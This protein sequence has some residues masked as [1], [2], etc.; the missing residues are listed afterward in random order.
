MAL[1]SF[2]A[3][4]LG[5]R[6][7]WRPLSTSWRRWSEESSSE[8]SEEESN[9]AYFWTQENN[10]LQHQSKHAGRIYKVS[11]FHASLL[12]EPH[13]MMMKVPS[14]IREAESTMGVASEK[15]NR[16]E[17]PTLKFRFTMFPSLY[18]EKCDCLQEEVILIRKP[19]VEIFDVLRNVDT[20]T[21]DKPL[22]L[23]LW[24]KNG[25]E[26]HSIIA[27]HYRTYTGQGKSLT[28]AHV[29]HYFMKSQD[30]V[31]VDFGHM[32]HWFHHNNKIEKSATKEGLFNH[33]QDSTMQ[34]KAFKEYNADKVANLTTKE[35][36]VWSA[37]E[38]TEK[39]SPLMALVEHGLD[40]PKFVADAFLCLLQELKA[41]SREGG[42]KLAVTFD[43]VN[44][45]FNETSM[46][47]RELENFRSRQY[48][49]HFR[50][51]R[52]GDAIE[53]E[54]DLNSGLAGRGRV[55]HHQWY[56]RLTDQR[57]RQPRHCGQ[58]GQLRGHGPAELREAC[59]ND[60]GSNEENDA[61]HG[62][63]HPFWI[64]Y[65]KRL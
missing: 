48:T 53:G 36:Y 22:K 21:M 29:K 35:E 12:H 56:A 18:E 58:R 17:K 42:C 15:V 20:D 43:G 59:T 25:G 28:L 38:K 23:V 8:T 52:Q 10:P 14:S 41:H 13:S 1:R 32:R 47:H 4:T 40:R 51:V 61:Q 63:N 64:A 62:S 6:S 46:A 2:P 7:L 11:S 30:F 16:D 19:A 45:L 24:G 49:S 27:V 39:G 31:L 60:C 57:R 50:K 65:A 54:Y 3:L 5:K 37:R 33:V 44:A 34:L 9:P 26:S 55:F